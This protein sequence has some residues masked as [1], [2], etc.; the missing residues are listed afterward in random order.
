MKIKMDGF[1]DLEKQLKQMEKNIKEFEGGKDVGFEELFDPSF[2]K[3]HTN[4]NSIN[5]FLDESPFTLETNEDFD[6]LEESELD[7]YVA[8]TTKFSS[9]E[10]MLNTAGEIH[11]TKKLGL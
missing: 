10:E 11:L 6:N 3:R 8:E 4:F 9:W 1:D 5:E 7:K 2:M